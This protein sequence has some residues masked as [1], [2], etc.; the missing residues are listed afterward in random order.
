LG[1][2]QHTP[3]LKPHISSFW[4]SGRSVRSAL[5]FLADK[6]ALLNLFFSN[7]IFHQLWI[8]MTYEKPHSNHP[9]AK[10]GALNYVSRSKRTI[11]EPPKGGR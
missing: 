4:L 7:L 3:R 9:P 1:L 11:H 5:S 8:H 6:A 2:E 10:P